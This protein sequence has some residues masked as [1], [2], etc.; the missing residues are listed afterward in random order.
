MSKTVGAIT[1]ISIIVIWI[2]C[3]ISMGFNGFAVFFAVIGTLMVGAVV[4]GIAKAKGDMYL[5][6][7]YDESKQKQK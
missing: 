7:K 3:F 2:L 1:L 6:N 5:A 4:S